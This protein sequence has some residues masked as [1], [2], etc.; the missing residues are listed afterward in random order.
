ME[1]KT[2]RRTQ[3][4]H[5]PLEAA[6]NPNAL[7]RLETVMAVTGMGRSTL[8][9]KVASRTFPQPLRFGSRCT[10]WKAADVTS[11]LKAAASTGSEAA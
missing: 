11:W 4:Q 8:Y 2:Q 3:R 5:Q 10:R 7:L 6:N 1:L 9:G